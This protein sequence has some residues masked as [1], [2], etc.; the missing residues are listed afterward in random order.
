MCKACYTVVLES[1]NRQRICL[2][3]TFKT[4]FCRNFNLTAQCIVYIYADYYMSNL[5]T[6]N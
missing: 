1:N 2:S 4:L 3:E 5:K 6:I